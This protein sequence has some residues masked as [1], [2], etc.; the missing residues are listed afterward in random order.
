MSP[1]MVKEDQ[2]QSLGLLSNNIKYICLSEN[3]FY[4]T[5]EF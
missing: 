5:L 1:P 2:W 4:F 3:F